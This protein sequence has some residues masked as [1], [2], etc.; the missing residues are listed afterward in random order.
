VWRPASG[1]YTITELGQAHGAGS[2]LVLGMNE[3]SGDGTGI[4]LVGLA[5]F[6]ERALLWTIP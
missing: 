4:E 6:K 2:P 5:Q 3:P 1:G